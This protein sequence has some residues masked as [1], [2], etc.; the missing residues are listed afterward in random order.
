MDFLSD[1][2]TKFGAQLQSPTLGFLMGGIVIAALGSQLQIPD[3][4]YKF[5][6]F[7][8]LIK[9]GLSGGIAIRNSN[10]TEMLLPAL[11]AV[12]TGIL[13]VF[14]GRY[15]LGKLPK[16]RTVDALATAG[17]FGAVSGSTLAAGITVMEAQ[18]MAY[19]PWAG[20]LYPFMDIPALVTAIVVASIHTSKQRDK[21][22][23]QEEYLSQQPV[24]AGKYPS[25]QEYPS[26]RQEYLTQQHGNAGKRVEIWPIIKESLQGSALSALLLGLALGIITR[27]ESVFESFYEPL[28]RGLLSIL[29]LVMGMEAW[30][31]I[32]E[33]RKVAQWY[34]VYALVAPLLHGFI[35]FG[36]GMIAHYAT[37]FSPGGVALLAI[38]AASS[39]DISGPPT[40]RAGIPS[41]NPSA[42]IGASTAV[43][44]P[45]AI[46]L[47]IPLYIG[48]AQALMGS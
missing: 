22:F 31:R 15:T 1:F 39:S 4:I 13:I 48:L 30:S 7:M 37:G 27:P 25:E 14:I 32:G 21:Y 3:A 28:F 42:Y 5:I 33:L 17:L 23:S 26:T 12:V 10:L 8:L 2:L 40:L 18:G 46:A 47:G 19:E 11:F 44:T 6:V 34:A 36:L 9:V 45:V 29:M 16:V 20:A 41:A 35:A 43:G 24:A 38:I